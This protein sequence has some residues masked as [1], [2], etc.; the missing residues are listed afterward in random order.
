MARSDEIIAQA[1][2][3]GPDERLRIVD[4]LLESLTPSDPDI[5]REWA[6]VAQRRLEELRSGK[7]S[8][9]PADVVFAKLRERF[10]SQ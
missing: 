3:L 9:I 10:T 5:D 7:V 8:G 6:A 2:S 4:A 1:A